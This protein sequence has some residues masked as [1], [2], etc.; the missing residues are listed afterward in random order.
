MPGF[1]RGNGGFAVLFH[2]KITGFLPGFSGIIPP[3]I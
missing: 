1:R 2:Q 3:E